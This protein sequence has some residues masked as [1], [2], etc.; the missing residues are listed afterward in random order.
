MAPPVKQHPAGKPVTTDPALDA[1]IPSDT[2]LA[3]LVTVD[4]AKTANVDAAPKSA[5]AWFALADE[6]MLEDELDCM[7]LDELLLMEFDE[8]E[9]LDKLVLPALEGSVGWNAVPC[10]HYSV[11]LPGGHMCDIA[12]GLPLVAHGGEIPNSEGHCFCF[13]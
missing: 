13:V 11:A 2:R 5:E 8:R 12:V 9:E 3:V 7:L 10:G 1:Q 6:D 4:P